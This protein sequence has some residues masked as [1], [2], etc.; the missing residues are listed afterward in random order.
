MGGV[1]GALANQAQAV[2]DGLGQEERAIARRA[3]LAMVRLGEGTR[4]SRRRAPLA[5]IVTSGESEA[6]VLALLRRFAEPGRRLITLAGAGPAAT[7][8]VAHEALFDHWRL[9]RQWLDAGRGDLRFHR[10]LTEA[11]NHW[12][13]GRRPAGSLWRPPDLDLL[14]DFRKRAGDDLTALEVA[15]A[16]ASER[17]QG[18]RLW[19]R[20][21]GIAAAIGGL[22]LVAGGLALY[23]RQ[24]T[25]FANQQETL[26]DQA[27]LAKEEA[28][29]QAHAAEGEKQRADAQRDQVLRTQSLF[30]AEMS[31]Q[32]TRRGDATNGIWLALEALPKDM[33]TPDRPYAAEAEAALYQAVLQQRELAVL[34]GHG[35]RVLSA[36]F[37]PE[38]ARGW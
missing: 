4:D 1:G 9:L 37:T 22:L 36:A 8:E 6:R 10:Q 5:E 12:D 25:E 3:F 19:F 33:A 14:R 15:F 7:A 38:R 35:E 18:R 11:A 23:S 24:Q 13:A 29:I 17:Q 28:F 26:R 30:L 27:D 32:E 2:Y 31:V 16:D 21:A 20:R 34:E